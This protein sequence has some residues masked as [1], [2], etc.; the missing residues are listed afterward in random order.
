MNSRSDQ[1]MPDIYAGHTPMMAQYL[2]LKAEAG[3]LLLFY[4][5]GD[6][7]EM[8]YED[9]ERGARLLNLTLTKRGSSNGAP[10]PMAAT[11][12]P[13]ATS[14]R[15]GSPTSATSTARKR[16]SPATRRNSCA[17]CRPTTCS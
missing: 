7:Y 14:A 3:P 4:R 17:A 11:W 12:K 9:A 8:F 16:T 6:F 5:M 13:S 10:I 1:A 15:S 2:R